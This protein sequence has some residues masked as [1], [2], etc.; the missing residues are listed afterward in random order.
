MQ[1]LICHFINLPFKKHENF[2]R[3]NNSSLYSLNLATF[4]ITSFSRLL[5]NA[6]TRSCPCT[7]PFSKKLN[8]LAL[9]FLS[10]TT[11]FR[12]FKVRITLNCFNLDFNNLSCKK[13]FLSSN[14]ETN[15]CGI[16]IK[17]FYLQD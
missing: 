15:F 7:D 13:T 12:N 9:C 1:N 2:C 10:L 6:L 16:K 11:L 3:L 17:T 4:Q 14:I 5:M 8:H